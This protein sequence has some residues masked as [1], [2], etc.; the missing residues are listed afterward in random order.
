[1]RNPVAS[2]LRNP[3]AVAMALAFTASLAAGSHTN[4]TEH[5]HDEEVADHTFVQLTCTGDQ[6]ELRFGCADGCSI[7][8]CD[9]TRTGTS[10]DC[11]EEDHD[12]EPEF[13]LVEC[14]AG[15]SGTITVF[16]ESD[17]ST[18][19]LPGSEG[20]ALEI[21]ELDNGVCIEDKHGHDAHNVVDAASA[22][23]FAVGVVIAAA[24]ILLHA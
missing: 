14:N 17:G 10:G 11:A 8:G 3:V 19:C 16:E 23:S 4:S 5:D 7:D 6:F 2:L 21:I 12:G 15:G 18:T 13:I 9:G 24:V 22:S 1:M 20:L